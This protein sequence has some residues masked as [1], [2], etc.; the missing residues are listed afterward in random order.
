LDCTPLPASRGEGNAWRVQR[1]S[2]GGPRVRA[3]AAICYRVRLIGECF[4]VTRTAGRSRFRVAGVVLLA[5]VLAVTL[6]ACGRKGPMEPPPSPAFGE[7][8]GDLQTDAQ[9]RTL[10]PPGQK[11]RIFLDAL[12]D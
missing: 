11:K 8:P 3:A 6:S 4:F 1:D 7:V 5:L 2:R 9:G 10:A 12:L